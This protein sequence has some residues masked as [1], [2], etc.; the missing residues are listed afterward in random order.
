MA[1]YLTLGEAALMSTPAGGRLRR[2]LI[3]TYDA[4]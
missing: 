4:I 1:F 3:T 2:A